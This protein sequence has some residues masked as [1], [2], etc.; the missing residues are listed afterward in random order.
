M[1]Q[2]T[3]MPVVTAGMTPRQILDAC[4]GFYEPPKKCGGGY[5]GPMVGYAARDDQGRQRVGFVYANF[6]KVEEWPS[7]TRAHVATPLLEMIR[8]RL[9]YARFTYCGLPEGGKVLTTLVADLADARSIYPEKV[10]TKQKT[11]TS[12]E[13]SILVYGRHGPMPKEKIILGEDVCNKFSTTDKAIALN[14]DAGAEV[15]AVM[16]FLNRSPEYDLVYPYQGREIPVIALWREAMPEYSQ[17]D[18]IVQPFLKAKEIVFAPKSKDG[19]AR[20]KAAMA[21]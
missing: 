17:D 16:C 7:I 10:V 3:E 8:D 9:G 5:F 21:A 1:T 13:E 6:A 15:V 19:W 20:L 4:D 11:E 12:K 2:I 14:E 18:A